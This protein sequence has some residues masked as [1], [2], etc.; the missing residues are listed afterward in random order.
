MRTKRTTVL[1]TGKPGHKVHQPDCPWLNGELRR[2]CK[3]PTPL[4]EISTVPSGVKRC[5]HCH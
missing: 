5:K 3:P 4:V 1:Y 2:A